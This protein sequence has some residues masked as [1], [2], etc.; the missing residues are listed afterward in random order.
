MLYDFIIDKKM[1]TQNDIFR[2]AYNLSYVELKIISVATRFIENPEDRVVQIP[3]AQY[4]QLL[5][6]K[7]LNT[8]YFNDVL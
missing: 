7:C 6:L 2:F 5:G 4:K 3:I 8:Q 1:E